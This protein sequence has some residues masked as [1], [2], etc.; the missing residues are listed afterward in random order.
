MTRHCQ[1]T[2]YEQSIA[3][4]SR[5]V[6]EP[7]VFERVSAFVC[8]W[9]SL[10]VSDSLTPALT[11]NCCVDARVSPVAHAFDFCVEL[12]LD[13]EAPNVTCTSCGR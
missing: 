13:H 11:P 1:S 12:T 7:V 6:E 3:V 10:A 4:H 5:E 2:P 8:V 9:V